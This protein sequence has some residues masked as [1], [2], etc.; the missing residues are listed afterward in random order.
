MLINAGIVTVYF[1]GVYPDQLAM[2]MFKEA[3]TRLVCMG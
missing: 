1:C 2:E 3:G